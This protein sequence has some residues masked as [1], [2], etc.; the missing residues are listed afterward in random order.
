MI[1]TSIKNHEL[2]SVN[3]SVPLIYLSTTSHILPFSFEEQNFIL[4]QIDR[5]QSR[6]F[7]LA[8]NSG[9][10][11]PHLQRLSWL[12]GTWKTSLP[13][14]GSYPGIADFAYHDT[15]TVAWCG[16]PMLEFSSRT[17]HAVSG[18]PMHRETGFL[19]LN[20][21]SGAVA[22][23]LSHN[24]GL[25]TVEEGTVGDEHVLELGSSSI[26]RMA[27]TKEPRVVRLKRMFALSDKTL[28]QKV[29][30]ATERTELTQHLE[31]KYEKVD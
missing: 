1:R 21:G 10:L 7:I 15:L 8:M 11:P 24:F 25:S 9:S 5:F 19:R 14:A 29:Y 16:Q 27:W 17:T 28:V 3:G 13:G 26:G 30:M 22:L 4:N 23:I 31:A 6:L 12:I 2:C 20:P 18:Q